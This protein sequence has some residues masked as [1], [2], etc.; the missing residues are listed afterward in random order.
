MAGNRRKGKSRAVYIVIAALIVMTAAI[1]VLVCTSEGRR[2]TTDAAAAYIHDN[3]NYIPSS[4]SEASKETASIPSAGMLTGIP[5]EPSE[6]GEYYHIL[7]LGEEAMYTTPGNGR[8]DLVMLATINVP[9]ASVQLVSLLRDTYVSIPGYKDNKLNSVYAK[10]GIELLY[11]VIEENYGIRPDGYVL[12]G[13]EGFENIVDRL[14]GVTVEL[15]EEEAE[16]LNTTKY[17]SK[18]EY[19]CVVPG[20]Q[21]LNGSQALG[22]CRVRKV[23]NINGTRYDYGRT[24]RQRMVLESLFNCYVNAGI[25]QWVPILREVMGLVQTDISQELL[26]DILFAVYD[27]K[28]TSL[29]TMQIPAA[30]TFKS[31]DNKN[32]VTSVLVPDWE[33]NRRLLHEFIFVQEAGQK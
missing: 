32:G 6:E 14:G 19:R 7:L 28:I 12:V 3:I 22:Y 11:E 31:V 16:Y 23:P 1:V 17:I 2:F 25:Y 18:P 8:T 33:E 13:F 4:R 30:G 21:K 20:K 10:G 24:E 9:A 5:A 29:H 26:E 27:N 15:T